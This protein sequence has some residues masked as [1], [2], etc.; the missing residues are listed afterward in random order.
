[1]QEARIS[2]SVPT[3]PRLWN[4]FLLAMLL[5]A[6]MD[7]ID[8]NAGD[9]LLP[10][11]RQE[12]HPSD[13]LLGLLGDA[14]MA[15]SAVMGLVVAQLA[16]RHARMR[17]LAVGMLIW[18]AFMGLRGVMPSYFGLLVVCCFGGVGFAAYEP[19][20]LALICDGY[21]PHLRGSAL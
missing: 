19:T 10:L 2:T 9:V 20:S 17:V 21:P 6:I 4:G 16:D 18:A 7:N 13:F 12:F 5:V 11:I 1:M 8:S 3:R 15:V 14:P